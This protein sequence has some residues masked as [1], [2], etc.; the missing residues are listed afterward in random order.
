MANL[1]RD[2]YHAVRTAGSHGKADVIALKPGQ[3]LLVQCKLSG[4]GG[5]SPAEWNALYEL[6]IALG[7]VA[8]VAHRPTRGRIEYLRITGRKDR[9]VRRPPVVVWLADTTG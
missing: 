3:V 4:P 8:L 2:G 1:E 9:P 6:A 5:V 7:A